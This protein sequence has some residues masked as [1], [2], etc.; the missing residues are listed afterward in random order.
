MNEDIKK[1][2]IALKF[3]LKQIL[4][5]YKLVHAEQIE[6]AKK[7]I[8]FSKPRRK[9]YNLCDGKKAVTEIAKILGVK[10]PT[11]THHLTKLSEL[12]F[13]ASEKR[14]GKKYF[15]KLI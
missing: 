12:G 5:L 6:E 10:Q 13:I 3:I 11:V 14:K 7:K 1:E 2:I 8:S 9:V 4:V 15:F